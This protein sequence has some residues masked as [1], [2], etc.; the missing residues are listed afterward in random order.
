MAIFVQINHKI[1]HCHIILSDSFYFTDYF[2]G[3]SHHT[4]CMC[5]YQISGKHSYPCRAPIFFSQTHR[6]KTNIAS[7]DRRLLQAELSVHRQR[8][9]RPWTRIL[10]SWAALPHRDQ[11]MHPYVQLIQKKL[12]VQNLYNYALDRVLL[13]M[14]GIVQNRYAYPVL[15]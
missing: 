2:S 14:K 15:C 12:F 8:P 9:F 13:I 10:N 5:H 4:E 1:V 6:K 7:I 11:K 3:C